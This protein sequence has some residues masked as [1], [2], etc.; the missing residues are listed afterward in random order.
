MKIHIAQT[1]LGCIAA[2]FGFLL[3]AQAK[4]EPDVEKGAKIRKISWACILC[5]LLLALAEPVFWLAFNG[6]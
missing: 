6:Y 3:R 5:G 2:V 1:I 4:R